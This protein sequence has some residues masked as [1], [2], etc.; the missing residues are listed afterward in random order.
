[1]TRQSARIGRSERGPRGWLLA[2]VVVLGLVACSGTPTATLPP[3]APTT[4]AAPAPSSAA[5]AT[6]RPPTQAAT[7]ARPTASATPRAAATATRP[8]TATT[9]ARSTATRA[10]TAEGS[11]RASAT[12]TFGGQPEYTRLGL[13]GEALTTIITAGDDGKTLYAG[14]KGVWRS[15]DAGATWTQLRT[16]EEAPA[17]SVIAVAPND[18]DVIY[19][20]VGQG[21]GKGGRLP[22]YVSTNGGETW[23]TMGQNINGLIVDPLD[24]KKLYVADCT[25]VRRSVDGGA[26]WQTLESA[27]VPDYTPT[28]IA[29]A[30]DSTKTI[31][32]AYTNEAGLVK[33]RRTV[34]D[35]GAWQEAT[36]T[37]ELTGALALVVAPTNSDTVFLTTSVGI[38]QTKNG[39]AKW[40][41]VGG[42]GLEALTPARPPTG[43]PRGFQ[44]TSTIL[45]DPAQPTILW[46]GTGAGRASG[47]GLFRSRDNGATW[48]RTGTGLEG[49]LV[50]AMAV[51]TTRTTSTLYI[52]T[53]DGV[54]TLTTRY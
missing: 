9:S 2:L 48:R 17:V 28:L 4:G 47:I 50:R 31:Y 54:W 39:G 18:P 20:G 16:A 8:T 53:D 12:L 15:L 10:A 30:Q 3:V 25:G 21:C 19:V 11:A 13:Q 1:M 33:V 40:E 42:D 37:G 32:V 38:Y 26:E 23:R 36:P 27:A 44:L 34:N 52:A 5:S 29:T 49:H 43:S 45:I 46:I 51:T 24:A 22:G 14:G 6:T 41:P 35:G 7:P